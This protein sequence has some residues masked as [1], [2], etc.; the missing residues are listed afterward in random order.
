MID[1]C[2]GYCSIYQISLS[3]SISKH[4]GKKI[5]NSL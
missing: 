5:D 1:V 4:E 3:L 2:P